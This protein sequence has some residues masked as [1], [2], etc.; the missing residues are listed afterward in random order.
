MWYLLKSPIPVREALRLLKSQGFVNIVP[1]K[2]AE[3][4]DFKNPK[5]IKDIY[6]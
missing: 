1:Y 3:V 4:V 6:M 2:G 5:Y